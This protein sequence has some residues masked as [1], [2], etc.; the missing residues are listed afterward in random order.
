MGPDRL[1]DVAD[2]QVLSHGPPG[3]GLL[4]PS[5]RSA[6]QRSGVT[7]GQAAI[8]EQVL[9][10]G[11]ELQQAQGVGDGR[12]ALAH[13]RGH[14][15]VSEVE[16]LDQLLVGGRLFEGGE[17]LAVEVLDQGLLDRTEVVGLSDDGGDGVEA[18]SASSP[19]PP[20]PGDEAIAAV[21]G[22]PHQDRLQHPQLADRGRQVGQR[23]LVEVNAR[24]VGVG[25][26]GSNRELLQRR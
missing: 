26:D 6:E 11:R 19:P 13:A 24:L 22:G 7:G 20:F 10:G 9:D 25:L 17:V 1:L 14:H 5:I 12:S 15:V 18:G 21:F 3:E 23:L 2:R 4:E 16:V 8:S